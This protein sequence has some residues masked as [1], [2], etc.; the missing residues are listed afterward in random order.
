M[1]VRRRPAQIFDRGNQADVDRAVVQ[2]PRAFGRHVEA[3]IEARR[4][5]RARRRAGARS[6]SRRRPAARDPAGHRGAH[7]GAR[8]R[9][10]RCVRPA[11]ARPRGCCGGSPRAARG[12]GPRSC[13]P[14]A[15]TRVHVV[16]ADGERDLRELRT[17]ERPVH[18]NRRHVV[19]DE[20]RQRDALHVVVAGRRHGRIDAAR[21][22]RERADDRDVALQLGD[23]LEQ[24]Q[25]DRRTAA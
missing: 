12:A 4:S 22:R 3:Q 20:P 5:R 24:R 25:R 9:S 14:P 2:Q 11:P 15:D 1:R 16:G 10:G 7:R 19:D 8:R 6:D 17:V 13:R 23:R 21:Q 18:L